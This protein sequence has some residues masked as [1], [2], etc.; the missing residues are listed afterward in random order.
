[1]SMSGV[2]FNKPRKGQLIGINNAPMEPRPIDGPPNPI[3]PPPTNP[4]AWYPGE[5]PNTPSNQAQS[6]ID[7]GQ[8]F[9]DWLQMEPFGFFK[10]MARPAMDWYG[11]NIYPYTPGARFDPDVERPD[12]W[13]TNPFGGE[14]LLGRSWDNYLTALKANFNQGPDG[15]NVGSGSSAGE[16]AV[17]QNPPAT[18]AVP[19]DNFVDY[20]QKAQDYLN[21][22]A[23]DY[24]GVQDRWID[25]GNLT[26]ARIQAMYDQIA[27]GAG[28]NVQRIGDIY[29]GA[30]E[31]IGSAY[32]TATANTEQ[33]YASAQQQAADQ[34]ARLGIEAAAPAVLNPAALSQAEAVANL[35]SGRASGLGATERYGASSGDF[36]SQMAQVAQQE[37]AQ[38][39][40]AVADELRRQMINLDTRAQQE[41]YDRALQV[42]SIAQ[43]MYQTDQFGRPQAPDPGDLQAQADFNFDI[44]QADLGMF[45]DS[46]GYYLDNTF[47]G[48]DVAERQQQAYD[49]AM[50]DAARGQFGPRIQQQAVQL[51]YGASQQ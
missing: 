46:Y 49:A 35:E 31:G 21:A 26:N 42:P 37:G 32:D 18:M 15:G 17:G 11:K 50:N 1:M 23:P 34:M 22:N 8:G 40:T 48:G 27:A 30:S 29:S 39:Q 45:N 2:N 38:Y 33:A 6:W 5:D 43:G 25:E 19:E 12:S 9:S 3:V 13:L 28:E 36:A 20:W 47:V 7:A 44:E 4:L 14:N 16:A 24:S 41:A 10:N 51:G